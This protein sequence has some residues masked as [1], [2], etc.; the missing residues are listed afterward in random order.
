MEK[1]N[2]KKLTKG[3]LIKL[4]LKK[5][6]N[7]EDLLDNDPFKDEVTQEPTKPTPPP[8]TGKWESVSRKNVNEDLILPPPDGYKPIP[9]PR[10]DRPLKI[11]NARRPPKP[12]RKPPPVPQVEEHITNVP[13]PKIKELNRALKGHAK[14]YEIELQDNLNPLNHFK[15]TRPQTESHLED[16]LKTMKGFKFIETLEVMFVKD[17][18]DSKTGKR[19][20]IYKTAFF[21]GKAKIITKVDDIEPELNM[22]RQEILNVIDKW[23]SEGSGW[24]I[25]RI[26]SHYLKVT[27]YKPLNGSSY[28]ELP[29]ELK[30]PKKGLINI[31]NKDDECFRWC[32]IR[33]LNLQDKNPQ[34]IKKGDKKMI[35]ELN[36]D[37]IDFPLSQKHYNKVEKQN[38]MRINIFGYENGQPFP[39][40]ISKE[41]FEDQ[42]NLLLITKDFNVL[43]KDFNAFMYNQSKH[44]ERTH[45]CMYCLQ[46]FSSERVLTNHVNNCLTING[47]QAIN[48]PKQGE[49]VLKFNN[50][51]KQLPVPFVIYA[52]FEA[53]TKKV[54][55]C[56]QSEEME[57]DKDRRS[58]TE[59]YQTHE[60]CGYGYK[61]VCCYDDKYSKYT[62][63]Y[64]GENAV[65]KFME[66]MLEEV[67]YCKAVIK[68]HFNKPLVMTEV[69]KQRFKT[70]DRC[71]ICGEKYTDKDVRIRDHCHI[72]G[73]FRGSAHQECNL[74]LR[75]KPENVKIPVIFHNLRGYD[76]HFIMQQI[77][78]IANKHGYTNKKRRKARS[79]YQR[80]PQ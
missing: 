56:K 54:Q 30:N 74:K 65:Y 33:H 21:N 78:E 7:H 23:V 67:E 9:K 26:D 79:Q 27:L 73:K 32:H 18:I 57:K 70:M 46:C 6:N 63:T 8:R 48:M 25:D 44:K 22:S 3:Q 40:H 16:L 20:S 36:Y 29:T 69:D 68:K 11:Q 47:A 50:F 38:S 35:N 1:K 72:T 13:V 14:S 55:G 62:R 34:R 42:M 4:L 80:H 15:K 61:V 24:V 5:V 77:G 2:L 59:A 41:T 52:D 75:V 51:H 10:T 39:I 12:T 76:S 71:H 58:Y 43:I 49:N 17:T 28:I 45:L 37:G 19:V 31:K 60:D 66:K 53:I 64:G